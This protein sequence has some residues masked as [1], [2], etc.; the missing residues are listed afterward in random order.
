MEQKE[1]DVP[2]KSGF[3]PKWVKNRWFFFF[4]SLVF[5]LLGAFFLLC[6]DK[7]NSMRPSWLNIWFFN[8]WL[9]N[10][11][12]L[13]EVSDI[14]MFSWFIFFCGFGILLIVAISCVYYKYGK[15]KAGA[16]YCAKHNVEEYPKNKRVLYTFI[17]FGSVVLVAAIYGVLVG[18]MFS[19][20][21]QNVNIITY[22]QKHPDATQELLKLLQAFGILLISI[23]IIPLCLAIVAVVLWLIV[24][25]ISLIVGGV[26]STVFRSSSYQEA[27]TNA[28][29]VQDR[30]RAEVNAGIEEAR[31]L[32]KAG[33]FG[34]N[35]GGD[36]G[37]FPGLTK[38]DRYYDELEAQKAKEAAEEAKKAEEL[39]AIEAT[40]SEEQKAQEAKEKA[41]AEEKAKQE[42]LA[43][44]RAEALA[45]KK[46]GT[47]KDKKEEQLAVID[48]F[49][50]GRYQKFCEIMQAHFANKREL[51]YELPILR[52]FVAALSASRLVFLQ[53][54]SGT[55]KST[56]PREF[57]YFVGGE[58]KFFPVQASWR[59]K[60]DVLGFYSDLTNQYKETEILINMY[61]AS[62]SPEN[63]NL[64]VL[65]EMNIARPEYYFADFLSVF[66]Y[67][68]KDWLIKIYQPNPG[69][70]LPKHLEGGYARIPTNTWFI[71]TLNIDDSTFTL[72]DKIYDRCIAIDF[73]ES[74]K[75][76]K[77]KGED[78][79]FPTTVTEMETFFELARKNPKFCLTAQEQAKFDEL[80]QFVADTFEIKFGNRIIRQIQNFLPVYVALGGT[81]N[82]ALDHLF[83]TK[84]LR[85]LDAKYESYMDTALAKLERLILKLYGKEGFK[86]SLRVVKSYKR[87]FE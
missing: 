6:I 57:M 9:P 47:K 16:R 12:H 67:P 18:L 71:G 51:Y 85:K 17:F 32:R 19:V 54:L 30:I 33:K 22:I 44:L 26:T 63:F 70:V 76:F 20:F 56:L 46:T 73:E 55:G 7:N 61:R 79:I 5:V 3:L 1:L 84:I 75:A 77:C 10:A 28:K 27:S 83:V 36:D 35:A 59:D 21:N 74:N 48:G 81:K 65:D 45:A 34:N 37:I 62:Y 4:A 11:F 86:G 38:I 50:F 69:E 72:S 53:G 52:A 64:M 8:E 42:E 39:A 82:E 49:P 2:K 66:E 25:L 29:I 40:K 87:R 41:E 15:Q 23:L 68:S 58:A 13:T 24:K 43:R 80:C 31:R 14:S 78:G 60:T